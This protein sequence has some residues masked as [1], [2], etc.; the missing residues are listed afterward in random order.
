LI[1]QTRILENFSESIHGEGLLRKGLIVAPSCVSCHTAHSILPHT[2]AASSI[3]RRNIAA[4]CATCHAEIEL[5][6]RKVIKGELWEKEAHVLPA[7][8]DCHQ[9]HKIRKV[10]Y[11]QGVADK[12]CMRCHEDPELTAR[13]DGRSLHV[14]GA[15][16]AGSR[17][18]TTTCS[19]CH[20]GV[21]ASR[22]RPCETITQKVDCA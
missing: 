13:A 16:L 3:A 14:E 20:T 4:T 5:V 17:H 10:F 1:H 12:D 7:C 15:S 9:P 22:L 18:A 2:D 8:V 21:S 19:Q 11:D 6:H